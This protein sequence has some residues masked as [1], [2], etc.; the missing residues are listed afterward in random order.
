MSLTSSDTAQANNYWCIVVAAIF[1]FITEED[2]GELKYRKKN[3]HTHTRTFSRPK[4]LHCIRL[5][6]CTIFN[7]FSVCN[8]MLEGCYSPCL[9][10]IAENARLSGGRNAVLE[11]LK[12]M[13]TVGEHP[14]IINL[15]GACT[16]GRY[17]EKSPRI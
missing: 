4:R 14:N 2:W 13:V 15:I 11:E 6:N 17:T 9:L 5:G 12:I 8:K 7:Y 3:T 1:N 16:T 10:Y